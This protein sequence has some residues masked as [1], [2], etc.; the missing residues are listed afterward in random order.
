MGITNYVLVAVCGNRQSFDGFRAA[1]SWGAASHRLAAGMYHSRSL[2]QQEPL[3]VP[4]ASKGGH[5]KRRK[6]QDVCTMNI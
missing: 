5:A 3:D 4:V 2:F 1:Y 6:P